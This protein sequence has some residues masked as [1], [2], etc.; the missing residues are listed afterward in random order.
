MTKVKICGITNLEDAQLA[1]KFGADAL[2]FNFYEK[3][4]RFVSS[5]CAKSIVEQLPEHILKFG[6]FVD[7]PVEKIKEIEK[8]VGLNAIQLH[9][10]ESPEFVANLQSK[11]RSKVIKALRV[12]PNFKPDDIDEYKA[13]P[14]LLDTFSEKEHGGT[15]TAF[16]WDIAARVAARTTQLYL[17]GGLT[18]HN[19]S[20]AI[21][22]ANPFAV[23]VC[24]GIE[25]SPRKK[26]SVKLI[27]FI[28]RAKRRANL[29]PTDIL[30]LLE[31]INGRVIMYV[32]KNS[33]SLLDVFLTGFQSAL[34]LTEAN[35]DRSRFGLEFQGFV[36]RQLSDSF[37]AFGWCS[38]ILNRASGDEETAVELFFALLE[39]FR[40]EKGIRRE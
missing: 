30:D 10:G 11:T 18:P 3:S 4:P 39:E 36:E 20:T 15:G 5:A 32:G 7:E 22:K 2:G 12:S 24:S 35:F 26:D 40:L 9:G 1:V 19:V 21:F 31:A 29:R 33:L 37:G 28:A 6:V 17:A 23:D 34:H 16:D 8:F 38:R 27:N 14:I 13:N 25:I